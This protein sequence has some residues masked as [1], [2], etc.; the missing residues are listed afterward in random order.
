[1][2]LALTPGV[3]FTQ[4][5]FG[6]SGFS[7]TRGWDVNSN[8]KINGARTGESLFLLNGAPITTT[9]AVGNSPPTSRRWRNS[10]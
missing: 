8:Y 9:E 4:E 1:M 2:L 3:V 7:G 10:R 5:Q 6:A